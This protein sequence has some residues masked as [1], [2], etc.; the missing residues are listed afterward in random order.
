MKRIECEQFS[1]VCGYFRPEKQANPGKR[2]EI[3]ERLLFDVNN[4]NKTYNEWDVKN[5]KI[6]CNIR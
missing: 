6:A 4:K 1:R 5:E 2:A 3:S